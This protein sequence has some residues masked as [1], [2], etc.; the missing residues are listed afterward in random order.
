M[1]PSRTGFLTFILHSESDGYQPCPW[2][3]TESA[4]IAKYL[5][6]LDDMPAG[7]KHD[8]QFRV[9]IPDWSAACQQR[10]HQAITANQLY[11]QP[12]IVDETP[13]SPALFIVTCDD[14]RGHPRHANYGMAE[15]QHPAELQML[16]TQGGHMQSHADQHASEQDSAR[17][18]RLGS[19]TPQSS[20]SAGMA[21]ADLAQLQ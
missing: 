4:G 14:A 1:K 19:G 8:N 12:Y 10:M 20:A 5:W 6:R 15:L 3:H 18:T 21:G 13:R 11:V 7:D 17:G 16:L 9:N 2:L